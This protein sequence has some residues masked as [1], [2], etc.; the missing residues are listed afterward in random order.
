[1]NSRNDIRDQL[2]G[3]R[4]I[5]EKTDN[6]WSKRNNAVSPMHLFLFYSYFQL[7]IVRGVVLNGGLDFESDL[8]SSLLLLEDALTKSVTD[9]RSQ[10]CK[11]A[12]V[13]LWFTLFIF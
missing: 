11:E 7:K 12:C 4:V 5:L 6:D 9:L 10:V 13:T 8:I 2:E 3:A 1:M